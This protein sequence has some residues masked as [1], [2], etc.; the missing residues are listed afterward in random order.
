MSDAAA[1]VEILRGLGASH[2]E[3]LAEG[4]F[5]GELI[6]PDR[7]LAMAEV[8]GVDCVVLDPRP[9]LEA[10]DFFWMQGDD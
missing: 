7:V 3:P 4:R 5:A 9:G 2:A 1:H 10:E 6:A 8:L